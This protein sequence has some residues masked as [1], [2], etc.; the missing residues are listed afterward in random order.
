MEEGQPNRGHVERWGDDRRFPKDLNSNQRPYDPH[1]S[2]PP[3][4]GGGEREWFHGP[5]PPPFRNHDRMH[6][7]LKKRK[8]Y[9]LESNNNNIKGDQQRP[10]N[11]AGDARR[12]E[13]ASSSRTVDPRRAP[14]R[15]NAAKSSV[16]PRLPSN[17]SQV[18][19]QI[20]S[21]ERKKVREEKPL[22]AP[23]VEHS[24]P[25][26]FSS[27]NMNAATRPLAPRLSS[28]SYEDD[29]KA[30]VVSDGQAPDLFETSTAGSSCLSLDTA[31]A[32]NKACG[33]VIVGSGK[34]LPD[35]PR[36]IETPTKSLLHPEDRK[37]VV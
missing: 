6:V 29:S 32:T 3:R 8:R 13:V 1:V 12:A 7:P 14:G 30:A 18:S 31:H 36:Q 4:P 24:P 5:S 37:S 35:I 33:M 9:F 26:A 19:P 27:G 11:N 15:D 25:H 2:G 10:K 21:E 20:N 22:V 17:S 28:S 34:G 16:C 23:W